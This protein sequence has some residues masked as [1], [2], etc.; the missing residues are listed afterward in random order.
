[1]QRSAEGVERQRLGVSWMF[2]QGWSG[3]LRVKS[4][5]LRRR[6]S[7]ARCGAYSMPM[8]ALL[9][10]IGHGGERQAPAYVYRPDLVPGGSA[11]GL[12]DADAWQV[13]TWMPCC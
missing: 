2:G 5:E 6:R 8:R 10:R 13:C 4:A 3:E 11:V 12:R 7:S 1:V 9:K